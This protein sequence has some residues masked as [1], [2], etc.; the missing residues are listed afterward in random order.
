MLDQPLKGI[1]VIDFST[2]GAC[3]SACRI[4]AD[5]GADVIKVEIPKGEPGRYV[6][7][8]LAMP[9]N[10]LDNPHVELRDAGKREIPLDMK[11]AEGKTIMEKLLASANVFVSNTRLASL[12]KLGLGWE[13]I[14]ARHPRLIW[15]HLTGFGT[16][17]PAKDNAG[18]DTVAYW[19]RTGALIDYTENGEFPMTPPFGLGDM[20]AS[21]SLAG[22]IAAACFQQLKTGQGQKVLTSLYA[23]GLWAVSSVVQ[24]VNRGSVYP[25]SRKTADSPLRNTYQCKD[26]TWVMLGTVEYERFYPVYCRMIGR[27]DLIDDPRFNTVDAGKEKPAELVA[28]FDQA[29][30]K[31]D[32]DECDNVLTQY[33]VAHDRINHMSDVITD[34]QAWQNGYLYHYTTRGGAED[35]MIGSP[36]KFGENEAPVH[37]NAPR[38]GEDTVQILTELGYSADQI[39]HLVATGVTKTVAGSA[40]G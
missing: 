17:G 22:A 23:Q 3:P 4:L 36:I 39:E 29:F 37:K 40:K 25:K 1:R 21:A 20:A 27:E 18:F 14:H 31:W 16:K 15:A 24:S 5:W 35:L 6:G 11:S 9:A 13:D 32:W 12:E 7:T 2:H 33:D 19:A 30:A 38:L 28:I 8:A 10:D 34:D 26:G